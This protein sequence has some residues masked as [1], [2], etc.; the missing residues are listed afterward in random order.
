MITAVFTDNS[1]YARATGLWQWDYGQ[2]LRIE[3]LHLPTAV[4]IHFALA[5]FAGDAITRVGTTKDGVTEVVIPESLLEHQAAGA[6]YEI[7]AWIYLA[8]KTSGETI[9]RISVQVKRRPK[10]EGFDAPEDAE[11]FRDA[12]EAVNASADRADPKQSYDIQKQL[13]TIFSNLSEMGRA[14]LELT[15]RVTKMEGG[16]VTPPVVDEYPAWVEPTGAHDAYN[17]GDKMTYTDGKRYI[18]QMDNCVWTPDAYPAGWKL[19]E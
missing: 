18:C 10:P 1:D 7:Y 2:R 12:I 13:E 5:E 11:L 4:E 19:V 17:T 15:D 6:T 14:I 16:S 8:D 9:K 3:G